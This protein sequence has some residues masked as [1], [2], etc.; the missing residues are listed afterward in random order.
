MTELVEWRGYAGQVRVG[1]LIRGASKRVIAHETWEITEM[2]HPAQVPAG[3]TLWW[4][5]VNRYTGEE[6]AIPPRLM[7]ARTTFLLTLE[8]EEEALRTRRPP[9]VDPTWPVDSDEVVLLIERLG[10]QEIASRDNVTGEITCPNYS[11]GDTARP[12]GHLY[13]IEEI[14][15]LRICHGLDT[16][17]LEAMTGDERVRAIV[18]THGPLHGPAA[19]TLHHKGFPHRHVPEDIGLRM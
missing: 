16:R 5:A 12:D 4:R 18:E 13:G 14:E 8:E 9:H 7:T 19:K 1:H 11:I 15:H 2:K 3:H 6:V 17:G 10:A